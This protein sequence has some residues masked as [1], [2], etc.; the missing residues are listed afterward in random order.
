M[1]LISFSVTVS[2]ALLSSATLAQQQTPESIGSPPP[3]PGPPPRTD[4]QRRSP[5]LQLPRLRATRGYAPGVR[6]R[7]HTPQ[8]IAA[9]D[10]GTRL[11]R[12]CRRW[13]YKDS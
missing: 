6:L 8:A 5:Q 2:L 3:L 12:S 7:P 11:E 1:R 9:E 4:P 13:L 10:T